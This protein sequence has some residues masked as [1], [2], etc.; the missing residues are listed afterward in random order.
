M[1]T[2]RN[3]GLPPIRRTGTTAIAAQRRSFANHPAMT[4]ALL[5]PKTCSA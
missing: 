3:L 5:L 4:L 2:W 1:A